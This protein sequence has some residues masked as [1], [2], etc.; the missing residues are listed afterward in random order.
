MGGRRGGGGGIASE[1]RRIGGIRPGSARRMRGRH[2][3]M[4]DIAQ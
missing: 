2:H 3:E 1:F 4:V